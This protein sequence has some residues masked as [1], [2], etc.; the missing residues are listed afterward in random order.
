MLLQLNQSLSEGFHAK[1]LRTNHQSGWSVQ[2][3][4]IVI[5]VNGPNIK[6]AESIIDY[7]FKQYQA[8]QPNA[9]SFLS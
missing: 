2:E 5:A 6:K 9:I 3:M 4:E 1:K 7:S 8:K